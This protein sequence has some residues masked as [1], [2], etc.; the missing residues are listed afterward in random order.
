VLRLGVTGT[1]TGV[2]KTL[3]ASAIL[4]M[5]RKRGF[6]VAAMKPVETGVTRG[7]PE[8]DAV[9]LGRAAGARLAPEDIC[10]VMLAD[11]L[12]PMAAAARAGIEID[13]GAI[14]LAFERLSAGRDAVV[15]ESDGGLLAPISPRTA[16]DDLFQH[17]RL[18]ALIVAANRLG[19]INHTMLTV[20]AAR[21][22]GL[23]VRAVVLHAMHGGEPSLAE[24][25]NEGTLRAL[26]DDVPIV[27]FPW[28]DD[29]RDVATLAGVVDSCGLAALLDVTD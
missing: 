16:F 22:A 14:D 17:W 10:P 12:A 9:R 15:I 3:V 21:S 2:G 1:D 26:L 29:P 13:L 8:C 18:D 5:L 7:D 28:V 4:A 24:A 25:T 6:R 11:P 27:T 19:A 20:E 23:R